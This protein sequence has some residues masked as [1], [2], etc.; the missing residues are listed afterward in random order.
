MLRVIALIIFARCGRPAVLLNF[1]PKPAIRRV[2]TQSGHRDGSTRVIIGIPVYD[3]VDMLDVTGPFEMFDWAGFE[4][5]LLAE[6][7]GMKHFRSKGF[8]FEVTRSF[9]EARD[10][11][12]IWVPGGDVE[13]L[14][15][16]IDDPRRGYLN[17]LTAQAAKT[18]MVCSVCEGAMLLAAAGLL[19]H[20]H[21]TT[22]WAFV[23]CFAQRFP[24]VLMADGNP[25]FVLDRNRLT[26]GGIS[27]GLDEALMLIQLLQGT[28]AAQE[29][30]QNTQ[31]YPNPPVSSEIPP[32][33][34]QCPLPCSKAS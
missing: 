13:A 3:K 10:Y 12:A 16:I 31:Y 21:A 22:H 2:A 9:A 6:H 18:R 5:D 24:K 11:D 32:A 8:A 15:A 17:F 4:I 29:V 19:D 26:G 1:S 23:P 27:S 14:A 34:A 20:Y 25:R 33:P 28:V 7:K 30:Q